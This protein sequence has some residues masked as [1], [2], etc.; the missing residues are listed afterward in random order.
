[1]QSKGSNKGHDGL[2]Q[3][4]GID[5][6]SS[7]HEY[8]CIVQ[9]NALYAMKVF[10]LF[11]L[12]V[13]GASCLSTIAQQ[14]SPDPEDHFAGVNARGD[15]GMGF[16][17]EKTTHHFHLLADGGAIEIESNGPSD[18]VSQEAIRQHLTMIAVKFSQGDFAIPMFIHATVPPGVETMKQLKSKITY[19]AENTERGAQLRM[20]T[21]DAEALT[22]IHSFLRFQIQDHQT[23]DSLE[24]QK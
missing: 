16:N 22:A 20:T 9:L 14:P 12:Y 15:Q 1:M 24:V 13:F 19:E 3:F 5:F 8:S 18:A 4:L 11:F 2:D 6:V 23:G 7:L 10:H 21:H 17:H